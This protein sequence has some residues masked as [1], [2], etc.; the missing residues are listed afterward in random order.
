MD[1]LLWLIERAENRL[2]FARRDRFPEL[3][4]KRFED[5]LEELRLILQRGDD[6]N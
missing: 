3:I 2:E 1:I 6:G 4:V 5:H